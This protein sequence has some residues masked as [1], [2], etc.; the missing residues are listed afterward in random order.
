MK[1]MVVIPQHLINNDL[2]LLGRS[3]F[4]RR[5]CHQW[6]GFFDRQPFEKCFAETS[7]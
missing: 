1:P 6:N 2:P 4:D 5:F 3:D 7:N